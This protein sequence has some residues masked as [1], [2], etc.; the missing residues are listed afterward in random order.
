MIR[1][2]E[3][4][5]RLFLLFKEIY[6]LPNLPKE[7]DSLTFPELFLPH[8]GG[9]LPERLDKSHSIFKALNRMIYLLQKYRDLIPPLLN[10]EK[11]YSE[12]IEKVCCAQGAERNRLI[13][14]LP[15]PEM[16]R[17]EAFLRTEIMRGCV[18]RV[19][20]LILEGAQLDF[21]GPDGYTELHLAVL[22]GHQA[23]VEQLLKWGADPTLLTMKEETLLHLAA[24]KGDPGLV[25]FLLLHPHSSAWLY[26]KDQDGKTPLHRAVFPNA[27]PSIVQAL[28]SRMDSLNDLD[29]WGNTA[30]HLAV[31]GD[32]FETVQLLLDRGADRGL[33]NL[34]GQIPSQIARGKSRA[35]FSE[36]GIDPVVIPTPYL[37]DPL[38]TSS[39]RSFLTESE[40]CSCSSSSSSQGANSQRTFQ[41]PLFWDRSNQLLPSAH[42]RSIKRESSQSGSRQETPIHLAAASGSVAEVRALVGLREKVD[43]TDIDGRTPLHLAALHGHQ[44]VVEILVQ[45]GAN[46]SLLTGQKETLLH[47]A[48]EHGH[49]DL[50]CF[51]LQ[52]PFAQE[53]LHARDSDGKIPL[54]KAVWGESKPRIVAELIRAGTR[55]ESANNYGYRALHWAAKHGHLES[56]RILLSSGAQINPLNQNIESPFGLALRWRQGQILRFL[57]FGS[58][59]AEEVAQKERSEGELYNAFIR[60]VRE[61]NLHEQILCLVKLTSFHLDPEKDNWHALS[62]LNGAYQVAQ[63]ESIPKQCREFIF[64]QLEQM[65]QQFIH[66]I[67]TKI[68]EK[69]RAIDSADRRVGYQSQIKEHRLRLQRVRQKAKNSQ[70][71][72][73]TVLMQITESY[74][75]LL[76]DLL[77]E[78]IKAYGKKPPTRFAM[79][80]L[81]SMSRCEMCPYSDVEFLFLIENDSEENRIYFR[82]IAALMKLKIINLGETEFGLIPNND[83]DK[84]DSL[85]P[86][87]FS[88]DG[89]LSPFGKQGI[90]ELIGT[91]EELAGL[92]REE[93]LRQ[94]SA[95]IIVV[96]AMTALSF[97]SGDSSLVF[98]YQER[99]NAI[100][101]AR[102]SFF[103]MF[104]REPMLR[105]SRAIELIE[106]H[107]RE[108]EP[109]L[110]QDKIDLRGFDVKKELYRPIQTV[111][112]ALALYYGLNCRNTLEQL[113]E[114]C[115]LN[116]I[117]LSGVANLK[118]VFNIILRLR[119]KTHLFYG[120][121]KEVL[122]HSR[123]EL[124]SRG[125]FE[126]H[127]RERK[128]ITR[129]YQTL[130]PFH[131]NA[132]RFL[133]GDRKAFVNG[134]FH[135]EVEKGSPEARCALRPNP[136]ALIDL[137][138][139]QLRA[140]PSNSASNLEAA[141]AILKEKGGSSSS[142][143]VARCYRYLGAA[144]NKLDEF[145]IAIDRYMNSLS[146]YKAIGKS[147]SYYVA[148]VYNGLSFAY[149][150]SNNFKEASRYFEA[151]LE[152]E[153]KCSFNDNPLIFTVERGIDGEVDRREFTLADTHHH[154]GVTYHDLGEFKKSKKSFNKSLSIKERMHNEEPHPSAIATLNGLALVYTSLNK[155]DKAIDIYKTIVLFYSKIHQKKMEPSLFNILNDI[156][157]SEEEDELWD[158]IKAYQPCHEGHLRLEIV[159]LLRLMGV[160]KSDQTRYL[161][162]ARRYGAALILCRQVVGAELQ[163][164]E[165][166]RDLEKIA[167]ILF[168]EGYGK[169]TKARR[170]YQRL[171]KTWKE[172]KGEQDLDTQRLRKKSRR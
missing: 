94:H 55:V 53:W 109:Q 100:L 14:F 63:N 95:E 25:S 80:A 78:S 42:H 11:V 106:G 6:R 45:L 156:A 104:T 32:H 108:F 128:E 67:M 74:K 150:R 66:K 77:E 70:K 87:G 142:K 96:N 136:S 138:R 153:K 155:L 46:P 107:L 38:S 82:Q 50:V 132:K 47:F 152:L 118:E 20:P 52:R 164:L 76:S 158:A 51:L 88:I 15:Q 1:E 75:A 39:D 134:S 54:H 135:E 92:Q 161:S 21:R 140:A 79:A 30:L 126:I 81:G 89:G 144:Y 41:S 49:F 36:R 56:F 33:R 2:V 16:G 10:V 34:D 27:K 129:V 44:P 28:I 64:S 163:A 110:G 116:I 35:L 23:I 170:I 159:A 168:A 48:A 68:T 57:L 62:L 171:Y 139:D 17:L 117:S 113:D 101:N 61:N 133:K 169:R 18:E 24:F 93:W 157:E 65:E 59:E 105:E 98:Q 154:L 103:S 99:M 71:S 162:S 125:L 112:S 147:K 73:S 145:S 131:E 122:Y 111:I 130:I 121:E 72:A 148:E 115:A 120:S 22:H 97:V 29:R 7:L 13:S 149:Y 143:T 137:A 127:S 114:L 69:L 160:K 141:V 86:K 31:I 3:E 84:R 43:A 4:D 119:L 60:A 9:L 37:Y 58:G 85:T 83:E 8:S 123:G 26:Q 5:R 151:F 102:P 91:P 165:I 90:Y 12:Y 19:V 40:S 166:C 146:I 124:D 167:D 172:V